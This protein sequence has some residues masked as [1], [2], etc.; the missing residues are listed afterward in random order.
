MRALALAFKHTLYV[1]RLCLR[2]HLLRGQASNYFF[3]RGEFVYLW[4]GVR[5]ATEMRNWTGILKL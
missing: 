4:H 1:H 5:H 2:A 3:P